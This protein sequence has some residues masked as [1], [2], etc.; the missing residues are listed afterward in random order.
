MG[1]GTADCLKIQ[2]IRNQRSVEMALD[3]EKFSG[4]KSSKHQQ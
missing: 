4:K 2:G 1:P 3:L